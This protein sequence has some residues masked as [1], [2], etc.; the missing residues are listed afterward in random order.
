MSD[1]PKFDP[2]APFEAAGKPAFDPNAPFQE[3]QKQDTQQNIQQPSQ[4]ESA[5]R[6]FGQG[7]T[8]GFSD[9]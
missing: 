6:G 9:E 1:K 8:L 7:A 2:N 4:L 3:I 5:L